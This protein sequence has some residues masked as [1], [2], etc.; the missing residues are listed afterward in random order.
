M[1]YRNTLKGYGL[2]ARVFHALISVMMI[3]QL[4]VGFWMVGLP[5]GEKGFYYA[6]HKTFGLVLLLLVL[7]RLMWRLANPLPRFPAT[8][9]WYQQGMARLLQRGFYLVM[10]LLPITGWIFSTLAG[11]LP[12][13]PGLGHVAFPGLSADSDWGQLRVWTH[14]LHAQL[15]WL[16][17]G[18][19]MIHVLIAIYHLIQKD[20]IFERIFFDRT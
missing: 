20:G 8:I 2:V 18:M 17:V 4:V 9:H 5:S 11:F 12:T 15:G 1:R 14:N 3:G 13:F 6:N 16:L 19:I 10:L 7:L